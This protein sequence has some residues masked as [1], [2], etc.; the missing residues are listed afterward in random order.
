MDVWILWLFPTTVGMILYAA[1]DFMREAH[2]PIWIAGPVVGVL[3][4][5]GA[6]IQKALL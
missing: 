4:V 5:L 6:T 3:S 2:V 1:Y